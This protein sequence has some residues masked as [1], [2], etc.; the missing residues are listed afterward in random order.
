MAERVAE[1]CLDLCE[2]CEVYVI[3]SVA[4]GTATALSDLDVLVVVPRKCEPRALKKKVLRKVIWN[5]PYDY[6]LNL[7]IVQ[8]G[9]EEKWLRKGFVKIK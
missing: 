3:G 5:I 8:K 9:E 4:R 7:H 2:D 1:T 6:P